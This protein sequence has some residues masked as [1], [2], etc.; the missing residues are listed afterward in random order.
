MASESCSGPPSPRIFGQFGPARSLPL[1]SSPAYNAPMIIRKEEPGDRATIHVVVRAAFGRTDEAVLVDRLRADGDRVVSL[2]AV[3][4]AS[5]VGHVMLSRMKAPFQAL[6]LAPLS[7]RPDRQKSGIG[8]SLVREALTQ[9]RQGRFEAVFVL[10]DPAFYGRFGFRSEPASGFT[11]RY[12]GPHL[13]VVAL[14][15]DLPA[16]TGRIDY[17]SAFAALG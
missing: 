4:D 8:S 13:M 2:I 7:V 11:S 1:E 10:G 17:S 15:G 5:L 14:N 16:R 9:A 6:G 12:A 3:D